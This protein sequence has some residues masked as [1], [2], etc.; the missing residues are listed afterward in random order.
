ML[1]S[2]WL[3]IYFITLLADL[4]LIGLQMEPYRYAT[5][6]L[7]MLILAVYF[8]SA[9][10]PMPQNRRLIMFAALLFSFAGDVL[11]LFNNLFL[12]G[13]IAFLCAHICYIV[14]FLKI[15][16]TNPPVVLCR[17]PLIFLNAALLIGFIMFMLPYLGSMLIPVMV[18]CTVIFIMVQSVLHCFHFR[19]QP[20][21]WYCMTGAVLF[22]ISDS[23]IAVDKFYH[24]LPAGGIWVMLTY[25][26]A[27]CGLVYGSIKY[28]SS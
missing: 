4:I 21:A 10:T 22:M 8:L 1:K 25:G 6:P 13:L 5:K 15:R 27:Q 23:L 2:K 11:L 3:I 18:Y 12:P 26:L 7:L 16:Y 28:F 20:A 17:Y 9:R 19:T 14:F 24:P